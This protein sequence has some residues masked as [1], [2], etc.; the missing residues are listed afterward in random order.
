MSDVSLI[1]GEFG[2]AVAFKNNQLLIF[3]L[4]VFGFSL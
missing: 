2:L 3:T 4:L 1:N